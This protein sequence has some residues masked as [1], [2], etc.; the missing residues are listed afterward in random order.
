MEA[1]KTKPLS[2]VQPTGAPGSTR[3][4][5]LSGNFLVLLLVLPVLTY[6]LVMILSVLRRGP[7]IFAVT[8]LVW[9]I[10][11]LSYCCVGTW[12]LNCR[13]SVW[14]GR[15]LA[16]TYSI[17]IAGAFS[18][19]VMWLMHPPLENVPFPRMHL[20][21]SPAAN[22]PGIHG[23]IEFTVNELGV[24]GP[25]VRLEAVDVRILCVGGST[26]ECLYQTDRRTW[27]CLLQDTL[28]R[29]LGKS[30]FVGNA[31]RS[32]HITLN[33]DYLLQNYPLAGRFEWVVLLCGWNDMISML[34]LRNYDLRKVGSNAGTLYNP[35]VCKQRAYY[36]DLALVRR[37]KESLETHPGILQDTAGFWI[38]QERRQRQAA[39][40]T[41]PINEVPRQEL[42][43]A[44]EEYRANLLRI[45]YTCGNQ[46]QRLVLLTQPAIYRKDL[47]QELE[48]LTWSPTR[49]GA[50]TTA[51]RQQLMDAF[52]RTMME[53]GK[54][55]GIDCV[56]LATALPKDA[57][58][59]FDDVHFTDAGCEKVANI[60]SDYFVATLHEQ[61]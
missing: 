25:A 54:Q 1:I 3:R 5:F 40:R 8:D 38:E 7:L 2:R 34:S 18:E 46:K 11:A 59:F 29:R 39:L 58:V 30:V 14:L 17:L 23:P 51:V 28:T 16:C 22:L 4:E 27:P 53:V 41:K 24:R 61:P 13:R 33:H 15:F 42:R 52:N 35:A 9:L 36:E 44:L 49:E 26:T 43:T 37:L 55:Q 20:V 47:P 19:A 45:I 6:V 10:L 60:V 12:L 50:Y 31:G 48:R 21:Y 57:T 32:G 56:D